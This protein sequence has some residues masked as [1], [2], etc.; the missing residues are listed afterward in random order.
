MIVWVLLGLQQ[1][2]HK[3]SIPRYQGV[4]I[5]QLQRLEGRLL[6]LLR[7]DTAG[8]SW[9]LSQQQRHKVEVVWVY[10]SWAMQDYCNPW[11]AVPDD[12][13]WCRN[14]DAGLRQLTTGRNADAG[15]TFFGI[16]VFRHLHVIFQHFT[17]TVTPCTTSR[18]WTCRAIGCIPSHH[19]HAVRTCRVYHFPPPA[20]WTCRVYPLSP[21]SCSTETCMVYPFPPRIRTC[22]SIKGG[23]LST[24]VTGYKWG[25]FKLNTSWERWMRTGA[26]L[27]HYRQIQK[28]GTG[29]F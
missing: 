17:A 22:R 26:F 2:R 16:L 9:V 29:L 24:K 19:Q 1:Q 5:V 11:P 6:N 4:G 20:V 8:E 13:P 27:A 23:L 14:A 10:H 12:W 7:I 15:L 28:T 3:V 21:S 25:I 18:L